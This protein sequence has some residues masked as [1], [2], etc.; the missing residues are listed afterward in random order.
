MDK[1]PDRRHAP[2]VAAYPFQQRSHLSHSRGEER[3]SMIT[4]GIATLLAVAALVVMLVI[5]GGDPAKM[6]SAALFGSTLVLLYLSSTVYHSFHSPRIK[7]FLQVLDHAG[8]YLLIAGS[9]TPLTLVTLRGPWGWT[10]LGIIW[11]LA[12]VGVVLKAVIRG[13]REAWWSTALYVLMGWLIVIA[14]P[15]LVHEL[16][17]PGLAWLVAGGLCYTGGVVFFLWES[18]PYNHAIWHAFVMAGSAC[19]VVTTAAYVLP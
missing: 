10:L 11:F 17:L 14:A 7:S 19:H 4:H 8:I 15:K 12:I 5:A 9:Y 2:R 18:L 6:V 13:N 3:A 1:L 16:S